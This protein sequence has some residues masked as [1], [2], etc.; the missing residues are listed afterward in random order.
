MYIVCFHWPRHSFN[1]NSLLTRLNQDMRRCGSWQDTMTMSGIDFYCTVDGGRCSARYACSISCVDIRTVAVG[2]TWW[3]CHILDAC[4]DGHVAI[5]QTHFVFTTAGVR[6]RWV[7][8]REDKTRNS[9]S[10]PNFPFEFRKYN[11]AWLVWTGF[12]TRF[13]IVHLSS[14]DKSISISPGRMVLIVFSHNGGNLQQI[15]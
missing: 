10:N 7:A 14:N 12:Y 4:G 5:R 11:F 6:W 2:D 1:T 3:M 9:I 15:Q 13:I 8:T